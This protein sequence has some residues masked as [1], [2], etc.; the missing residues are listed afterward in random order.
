[1]SHNTEFVTTVSHKAEFV[2]KTN[3]K[4]EIVNCKKCYWTSEIP[5]QLATRHVGNQLLI[6]STSKFPT[7]VH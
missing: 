2:T 7:T 6:V 3:Q 5:A 1:M 4:A